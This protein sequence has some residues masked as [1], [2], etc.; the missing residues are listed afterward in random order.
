[1]LSYDEFFFAKCRKDMTKNAQKQF[2][3]QCDTA[4]TLITFF[5]I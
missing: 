2:I 3:L 4:K 5:L 1:V